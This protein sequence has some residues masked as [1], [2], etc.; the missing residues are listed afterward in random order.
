M[1]ESRNI[2]LVH[3]S[4]L[5]LPDNYMSWLEIVFNWGD[6]PLDASISVI[7]ADDSG[8]A[9]TT[10]DID[11]NTKLTINNAVNQIIRQQGS[12][13][14]QY[15]SLVYQKITQ[16]A[17]QIAN[18]T[19]NNNTVNQVI[20]QTASQIISSNATS[21]AQISQIINQTA[22]QVVGTTILP[23]TGGNNTATAPITEETTNPP[24]VTPGS[25]NDNSTEGITSQTTAPPGANTSPNAGFNP[26]NQTPPPQV[27]VPP[28]TTTTT[29]T[30]DT[31]DT[32]TDDTTTAATTADPDGDDGDDNNP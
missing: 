8:K 30:D 16:N 5:T 3:S 7:C 32:T 27:T 31:T 20:N 28:D 19:G 2:E 21:P 17:I 1:F 15:I 25:N 9:D 4:S 23:T 18:I 22:N 29:T 10:T 13:N 26:P 11:Y 24:A 12:I 14:I 6:E